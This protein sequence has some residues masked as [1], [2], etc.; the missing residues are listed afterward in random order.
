MLRVTDSKE[1]LPYDTVHLIDLPLIS[2]VL[3]SS[4]YIYISLSLLLYS[5]Y[6]WKG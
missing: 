1:S 6:V 4:A 2:M 3:A 5:G